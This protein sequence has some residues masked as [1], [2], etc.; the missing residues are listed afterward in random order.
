[1]NRPYYEQARV[2]LEEAHKACFSHPERPVLGMSHGPFSGVNVALG[3]VA[4]LE[5]QLEEARRD[6]AIL[7]QM[8]EEM[9]VKLKPG[10]FASLTR[11]PANV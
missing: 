1:M 9:G 4:S 2:A 10:L 6:N 7:V 3:A 8:L 5:E 11:K